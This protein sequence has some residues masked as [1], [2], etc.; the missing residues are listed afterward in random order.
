MSDELEP[1]RFTL[2]P[3][4]HPS[5]ANAVKAIWNAPNG[6]KVI[7]E[8]P[9]RTE[10]QNAKLHVLL[11][12]LV[13]TGYEWYGRKLTLLQWKI[14]FSASLFGQ[15][16]FPSLD[17]QGFVACGYHTSDMTEKQAGAMIE[18]IYAFC[19]DRQID[20]GPEPENIAPQGRPGGW[21]ET[22]RP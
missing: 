9:K 3:N 14:M 20:L 1:G 4:P 18:A 2:Q 7:I 22:R 13:K 12:R 11:Q 15:E 8:P 19:G 5:R 10:S 17:G 6:W 21:H 16:V